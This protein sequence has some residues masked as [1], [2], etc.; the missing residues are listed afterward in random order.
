M[1]PLFRFIVENYEIIKNDLNKV[2][3]LIP[4]KKDVRGIPNPQKQP[5]QPAAF[6]NKV[7]RRR[8]QIKS[9]ETR[10]SQ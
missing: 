2:R 1:G 10:L 6:W 3:E 8:I 4:Q 5:L 9:L 7:P